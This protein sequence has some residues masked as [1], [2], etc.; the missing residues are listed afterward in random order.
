MSND[1]TRGRAA[2]KANAASAKGARGGKKRPTEA[3]SVE[4]T[5]MEGVVE[6]GGPANSHT[7][8]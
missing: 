7:G 6:T 5:K 1:D 8:L 4:E 3:E 2:T